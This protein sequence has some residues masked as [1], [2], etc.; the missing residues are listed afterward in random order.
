MDRRLAL[1]FST[2]WGQ[3]V[4]HALLFNASLSDHF[5]DALFYDV[6][7]NL[8]ELHLSNVGVSV[9]WSDVDLEQGP[10]LEDIWGETRSYF[11]LRHYRLPIGK[12]SIL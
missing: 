7:T 9:T 5:T 3:P 11:T 12:M 1:V 4:S 2:D 10:T 6:Y 8:A